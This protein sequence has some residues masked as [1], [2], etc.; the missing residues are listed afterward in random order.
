MQDK[1]GIKKRQLS[2]SVYIQL[3]PG[4]GSSKRLVRKEV[5]ITKR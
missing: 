4:D 1:H 5:N 2:M 3:P